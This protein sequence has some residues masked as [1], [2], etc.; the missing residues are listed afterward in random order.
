MISRIPTSNNKSPNSLVRRR[1]KNQVTRRARK[2]SKEE[3]RVASPHCSKKS[4]FQRAKNL[5]PFAGW[6]KVAE[7]R[8]WKVSSKYTCSGKKL[9]PP[10][11]R[12]TRTLYSCFFFV[13]APCVVV[14]R[15]ARTITY[16]RAFGAGE[17]ESEC[18]FTIMECGI[19]TRP[20]INKVPVVPSGVLCAEHGSARR[21][22]TNCITRLVKVEFFTLPTH[23][24]HSHA[25]GPRPRDADHFAPY[26]E[27]S[28]LVSWPLLRNE[29]FLYPTQSESHDSENFISS[30]YTHHFKTRCDDRF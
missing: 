26:A 27:P 22:Y 12:A 8:G 7:R 14:A 25:A 20:T 24:T 11:E 23:T 10:A 1:K 15:R 6:R 16:K 5:S 21:K 2:W 19:G 13:Y 30:L 29:E 18:C 28:A 4:P 17:C 3:V 9:R